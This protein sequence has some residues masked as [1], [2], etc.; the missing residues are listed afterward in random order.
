MPFEI[1]GVGIFPCEKL[2]IDET[3]I[4]HFLGSI[5]SFVG[6]AQNAPSDE[7]L[8]KGFVEATTESRDV[9]RVKAT[10]SPVKRCFRCKSETHLISACPNKPRGSPYKFQLKACMM[11]PIE[12]E[13]INGTPTASL[14]MSSALRNQRSMS[15]LLV[16]CKSVP[17]ST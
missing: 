2:F 9:S 11:T 10:Q 17:C 16:H 6:G 15:S 5:R 12:T 8:V 13:A 4:R 14:C 1:F 7:T 3:P